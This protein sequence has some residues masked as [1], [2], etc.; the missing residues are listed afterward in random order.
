MIFLVVNIEMPFFVFLYTSIRGRKRLEAI[1]ARISLTTHVE[2]TPKPMIKDRR[3]FKKRERE[4]EGERFA[5][6]NLG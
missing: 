1:S 5:L 3:L 6:L 2:P 4:R